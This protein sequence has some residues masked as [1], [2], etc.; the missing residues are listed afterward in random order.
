VLK[1]FLTKTEKD[2]WYSREVVRSLVQHVT[3]RCSGSSKKRVL[4]PVT[5]TEGM[6]KLLGL[7]GGR[8]GQAYGTKVRSDITK[9]ISGV[10][11][12]LW[13]GDTSCITDMDAAPS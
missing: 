13:K 8:K 10:V 1:L 2:E 7:A 4:T 11:F 6:Y 12:R 3:I 5:N 9:E